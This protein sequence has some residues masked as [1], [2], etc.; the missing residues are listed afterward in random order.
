MWHLVRMDAVASLEGEDAR[1]GD[2]DRDQA[3][4]PPH[5]SPRPASGAG[6]D[7]LWI[8]WFRQI[9][10]WLNG[11]GSRAR[12]GKQQSERQD[13]SGTLPVRQT[14]QALTRRALSLR[15]R[16]SSY[17]QESFGSATSRAR[18]A[19]IAAKSVYGMRRSKSSAQTP[20]P[21]RGE[22][23]VVACPRHGS[24]LMGLLDRFRSRKAYWTHLRAARDS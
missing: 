12:A 5:V 8:G 21:R 17:L 2:G 18:R 24:L 7:V 11:H 20:P 1:Q 14:A 22:R 16:D 9:V 15:P 3:Q 10:V 19:A 13:T 4:A 6:R 23:C